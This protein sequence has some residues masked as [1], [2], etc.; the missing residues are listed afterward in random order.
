MTARE[1]SA[2]RYMRIESP[3]DPRLLRARIPAYHTHLVPTISVDPFGTPSSI[4]CVKRFTYPVR[5]C[6]RDLDGFYCQGLYL[7]Y[8]PDISEAIAV[9]TTVE[10]ALAEVTRELES[11]IAK[12]I[13]F[14]HE[15]RQIDVIREGNGAHKKIRRPW[16]ESGAT[17]GDWPLLGEWSVDRAST[18]IARDAS[19]A[20]REV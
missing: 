4:P 3:S 20:D 15:I 7:A 11:A 2:G 1:S 8:C 6:R 18:D 17:V 5:I 9:G 19:V 16:P 10:E 14:G 12:R 13:V